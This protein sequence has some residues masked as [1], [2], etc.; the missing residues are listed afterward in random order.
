MLIDYPQG[1]LF[2]IAANVANEWRERSRIK[3]PHDAEWLE[4]LHIEQHDQPEELCSKV[5]EEKAIRR[6]LAWLPPRQRTCLNDH[7]S[8]LTYKQ[9]AE[10]HN[11]T[12]R[13]VLR[14]LTRAYGTL[15]MLLPHA[16]YR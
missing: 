11:L 12:Y 8:G 1:Y 5:T 4:E 16:D 7:V 13:I 15:R 3:N 6:A 9:I 10:K 14:D 2:R